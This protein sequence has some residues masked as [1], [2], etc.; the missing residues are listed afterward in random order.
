MGTNGVVVWS[1]RKHN[2]ILVV[3]KGVRASNMLIG[4]RWFAFYFYLGTTFGEGVRK[5]VLEEA[6]KA[7]L[8][9]LKPACFHG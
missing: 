7:V 4:G 5:N 2:T 1:K 9:K 8:E 6:R 3:L